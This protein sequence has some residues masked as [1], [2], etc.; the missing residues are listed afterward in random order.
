[1]GSGT[2][3]IAVGTMAKGRFRAAVRHMLRLAAAGFIGLLVTREGEAAPLNS[4][5][6]RVMTKK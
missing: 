5:G 2:G 3:G 6:C 4:I 1:M